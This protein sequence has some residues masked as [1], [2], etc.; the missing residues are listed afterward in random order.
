MRGDRPGCWRR[1][2]SNDARLLPAIPGIGWLEWAPD[3]HR[4]LT[5]PEASGDVAIR[6]VDTGATSTVHA[7]IPIRVASWVTD[8]RL[9]LA[10]ASAPGSP[11]VFATIGED[12]TGYRVLPTTDATENYSVSGDGK[13]FAYQGRGTEPG[14]Q[15]RIHVVDLADNS[16]TLLT[17]PAVNLEFAGPV[18]SPDGRWIMTDRY[19]TNGFKAALVPANG[20]GTPVVIGPQQGEGEA[21]T[22]WAPDGSAALVT[23]SKSGETWKF[24]VA[25]GSGAKVDWPG[26]GTGIAWQRVTP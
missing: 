17:K 7:P 22:A 12:G 19:D 23:Y 5:V 8:G 2:R 11:S 20:P 21:L 10:S 1:S 4:I 15:G 16:D 3:S 25:S 13:R 18:F 14:T 24:D 6:D 26:L 9:L